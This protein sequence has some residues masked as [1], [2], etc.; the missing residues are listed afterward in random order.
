MK[1]NKSDRKMIYRV[2]VVFAFGLICGFGV[3][4]SPSFAQSLSEPFT[5]REK[6]QHDSL[7]QF[8]SYP[9]PQDYG[10]EPSI[11]P[12][13]DYN[14]PG[15]RALM[16]VVKPNRNDRMRFGFIRQTFL[17]MNENA[18]LSFAY[19]LNHARV[20][21]QI[22]IGIAGS[23]D[24]RYVKQIPAKTN[25]WIREEILLRDFRCNGNKAITKGVGIEAFYIVADLKQA[26]AD[27]VYRFIIDD[28]A[29]QASRP[30]RFVVRQPQAVN[31]ESQNAVVSAKSYVAGERVSL[32]VLQ[33]AKIKNVT[34]TIEN[35]DG[36]T[37]TS[38]PLFDNGAN[39]DEQAG[40]GV[41][42]NNSI[43]TLRNGDPTGVWTIK[44]QGTTANGESIATNVRFI[45]RIAKSLSHPR[46]YF[47]AKDKESLVARTQNPKVAE[48]WK[49]V[50]ADAKIRRGGD[51]SH[52]GQ[53]FEML[54]DQ[55]LLPSLTGYFDA[56]NQ[57]RLR[58]EYN[59]L[60]AYLTNDR[61]ARESAKKALLDVSRWSRWQPP[62]FD[63]HGQHT[64]YPA[65]QLA[66]EAAFGY[67]LLYDDL[68][69]AE[70]S[71]VRRA[72]VER[73]IIPVYK[74]YVLDNRVMANTS[75][76]IGHTVGGALIAAAAIASDVKDEEAG[77]QFNIYLNG[78]LLKMERHVAASY[79]PDGSYGEGISYKEFDLET[80][81][82]AFVALNR[83][84]GIDYW[85]RTNI[86]KSLLYSMYTFAQPVKG[87]LDMGDSHPPSARTLAPLVRETKDPT[88]RW[89]FEQFAH[90]SI[91]DFIF[92]DESIAP[93]PPKLPTSRIFWDK[94]NAAFRT[95]WDK[96]ELVFLFRAG[97]NFN[98]NHADQGAFLLT[99]FGEPLIT[100]AGWSDYY[101]DPHYVTFFTQAVG[102]N[103][104]LVDGN[105]ESQVLPDTPQFAALDSYPKITDAVTSE[106]YDG[107]GSDLTSVY[108]NRLRRYTRRV[109]FVK[110]YYFIVFD[111]LTTN[112][113]PAGFAWLLHLPDRARIT[114]APA[115]TL[116]K[117]D[118]AS[119]A[120]R[121][122]AP[123]DAKMSVQNGRISYPVFS[124]RTPQEVPPQPAFLDLQTA[125]KTN[126][127]QFLVALVPARTDDAARALASGM[128][129]IKTGD[130]V[131][132]RARRGEE[133][134][135]VMFR[136][137]ASKDLASYESWK[138]DADTW[139]VT[140]D[141]GG[142][143]LFAVQN[144]RSF[145][146][147]G[148]VLF[149][150]ETPASAAISY[151]ANSIDVASYAATA[152]KMQIFVGT[153]PLR[154]MI[155]GRPVKANF[156]SGDGTIS[157]NLPAGQHDL[158]IVL[159]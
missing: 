110:P 12:T 3:F 49:K 25:G 45:H 137:G 19:Y 62:W 101:K 144:A 146:Q 23:D 30:A 11:T 159:K 149:A 139:T 41:W 104:V 75:N 36:K 154:V 158:K 131:G 135:L 70:R 44:L 102:H 50:L 82:P 138:T 46:L 72:L 123:N 26:D 116:Y 43:Y 56:M 71:L 151:N 156:R 121:A 148:R 133:S 33:P 42:T 136:T 34:A 52:A 59:A 1:K 141:K 77:G 10:Y 89:F 5:L 106:F 64:Y 152:T 108:Q 65:G 132:L 111:D 129:E 51:L 38:Q 103:T 145:A 60:V 48:I 80:T 78:L 61:E 2:F 109:V 97:A 27:I 58:I 24:C 150:S 55:Y 142:M 107:V 122:F 40:D 14:A 84:F 39:G 130:F 32:S 21:D 6:F 87:S 9:P 28:L 63:A 134:D 155:D 119:L 153:N 113:E 124:T 74:E 20:N 85:D 18:K 13:S 81:A 83:V 112:G 67:D 66:A 105:P 68:T 94:G 22:E 47:D 16:R 35:Q 92:F 54:D 37:I 118:K 147:T 120:V 114:N 76:W 157:V 95:G 86:K 8:A 15:G 90:N 140:Q 126:A 128:T 31:I 7:G 53:V 98:H 117:G 93:Q 69:E 143:K 91:I 17:Q 4:Q 115:L 79:L 100:E 57:A 127:A 96:D 88:D 29:F 73:A 99:A 125:Q